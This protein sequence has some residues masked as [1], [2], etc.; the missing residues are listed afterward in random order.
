LSYL[1]KTSLF[2]IDIPRLVVK[3]FS[4]VS[5]NYLAIPPKPSF[6]YRY[7]RFRIIRSFI[8]SFVIR[9]ALSP[10][11]NS[12]VFINPHQTEICDLIRRVNCSC[13]FTLDLYPLFIKQTSRNEAIDRI[14]KKIYPVGTLSI[15]TD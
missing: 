6:C 11:L 10:F 5:H 15:K 3:F 4:H 8:Y 9:F 1:G 13:D 7:R 2:L 12:S 14:I